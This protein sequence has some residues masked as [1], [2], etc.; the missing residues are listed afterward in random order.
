MTS[1]TMADYLI[2]QEQHLARMQRVQQLLNQ[3]GKDM[4]PATPT[5]ELL[6]RMSIADRAE[7]LRIFATYPNDCPNCGLNRMEVDGTLL[8][9]NPDCD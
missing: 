9:L 7:A 2:H 8:C 6:A 5:V 3:Y 4:P 1:V